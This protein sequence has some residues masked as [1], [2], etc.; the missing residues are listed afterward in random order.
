MNNKRYF[1]IIAVISIIFSVAIVYRN[2]LFGE[3][4]GTNDYGGNDLLLLH[5][6]TLYH[7]GQAL[8]DGILLQWIPEILCGFPVFAEGQ[9]GFLYPIN[10]ILYFLFDSITAMNSFLVIHPIFMGI[11]TYYFIK[12]TTGS[13]Y[14]ALPG[15]IAAAL[16]GSLIMGHT[17]HLSIYA[18]I[19]LTPF[20]FYAIEKF[21]S[22]GKIKYS[23]IIGIILGTFG[24]LGHP[25]FSFI[26]V[27]LALLYGLFRLVFFNDKTNQNKNRPSTRKTIL[28]SVI[29]IAIFLIIAL[30]QLIAT[31]ELYTFTERAGEMSDSFKELGSLPYEGI[32]LFLDPYYWGNAG[33]DSFE[34]HNIFY[35][36][37]WFHYVGILTFLLAI[38][39][40]FANWN[41]SG[42]VKTLAIIAVFSYLLALGGN[43]PVY[44][45]FSFLPA[46]QNFRFLNRWLFGTELS[47]IFLS[48][49]GIY[50]INDLIKRKVQR[51]LSLVVSSFAA[52]IVIFLDIFITVGIRFETIDP[53]VY[54]QESG[55]VEYLRK[56]KD[57]FRVNSY[58][59]NRAIALAFEMSKGWENDQNNYE[60]TNKA[61]PSN[62]PA[63][64]SIYQAN[65][66]NLGLIPKYLSKLWGSATVLGIIPSLIKDEDGFE[67]TASPAYIRAMQLFGVKYISSVYR[68]NDLPI[69]WDSAMAKIQEVPD[70]RPR[71]WTVNTL[72]I[73]PTKY[74]MSFLN[75]N[76]YDIKTSAQFPYKEKNLPP[77]SAAGEIEIVESGHHFIKMK[78]R[79][80]GLAVV[81]DTWYP[82]WK[83]KVNGEKARIFRVNHSMRGVF[84][85]KP[86]ST[87][88]MEFYYNDIIILSII[89]FIVLII[90]IVIF[91][92]SDF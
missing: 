89:S 31:Y 2:L 76:N 24:L 38:Y 35:F 78:V 8:K 51:N 52:S 48:G 57:F 70:P 47:I 71:A 13:Q 62:I 42:I 44:K 68:I 29:S 36:W 77:N 1:D 86:D 85:E 22:S 9:N 5:F 18:I 53:G 32:L 21:I 17:R 56:E 81:S 74:F 45:I 4:I 80:P 27:F 69:V 20:L 92:K 64:H 41:R 46:V 26:C 37:E 14:S 10:M 88:E 39:G 19:S 61:L 59:S 83:A 90:S 54:F 87:I 50:A 25:Q 58:N 15:A 65:S 49:Y 82:R 67:S 79:N 30:P 23:F 34:L 16:C 84:V 55:S 28:F 72:L 7:Y 12:Q 60:M 6:P 66:L 43:L 73:G 75:N 3:I 33:T 40:L 63:Y 11:G 91:I